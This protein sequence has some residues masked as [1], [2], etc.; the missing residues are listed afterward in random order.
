MVIRQKY[1]EGGSLCSRSPY[2]DKIIQPFEI[3]RIL[4]LSR[5]L[6]AI[7]KLLLSVELCRYMPFF[8][9]GIRL[10]KGDKPEHRARIGR[11]AR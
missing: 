11:P 10:D 1:M 3:L 6:Y 7:H 2:L 9:T 5:K 8:I 4:Y